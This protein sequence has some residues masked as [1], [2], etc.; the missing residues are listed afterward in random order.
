MKG[1]R[2]GKKL[3]KADV[4]RRM[5]AFNI[6]FEEYKLLPLEKLTEMF[7]TLKGVYKKACE[8]VAM[9]KTRE[10]HQKLQ[11]LETSIEESNIPEAEEVPDDMETTAGGAIVGE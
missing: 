4:K 6:K 8:M 11:E 9:Q 7:P 5:E 10:A 3:P 2:E 1:F